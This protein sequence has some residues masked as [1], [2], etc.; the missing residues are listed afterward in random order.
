[1]LNACD[2]GIGIARS[3]SILPLALSVPWEKARRRKNHLGYFLS[4]EKNKK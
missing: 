3:S 2:L 4:F 1:V